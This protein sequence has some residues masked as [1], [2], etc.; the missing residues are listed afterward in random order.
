MQLSRD[1]KRFLI[2]LAAFVVVL[3]LCISHV[4]TISGWFVSALALLSPFVVGACMAFIIS[5]PMRL[6]DRI[7]RKKNKAGK[8]LVKDSTRKPLSMVLAIVL[9]LCLIVLFGMIVVPQL[10]DTVTSLA[11]SI[12]RFV[13]TA[14]RWITE[15]MNWLEGYPEIH[16]AI[17]PMVPDLNQVAASMISFV[18]KYAGIFASSL[19]SNVSSLFGSATDVII[20]FVFAIYILLQTK[21]LSR[22]GKKLL[23]AF[24]PKRFCDDVILIA[25]MAHKT[26]FSYVT[27][28]CTEAV[29]LGALCFGGMVIFRFPHALVISVI[30]LFCALIPIYGAI[31]SCVIGAF[32]V[33]IES[34]MKAIGFVAFI[35]IL[36]QLETNLIYPR[37]VSTSINLPSMWVMLAVTVGGGMF[38]VVGMLTAVPVCSIAYTLLAETTRFALR[39][40]TCPHMI[41][42]RPW[43][44]I[45]DFTL[46]KRAKTL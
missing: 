8:P 35:L 22:Q 36:Q 11:G 17:A 40:K 20:S 31:I 21:T 19:V 33:L 13:P 29:I 37:V 2:L 46:Q 10:V 12:M 16:D 15:L 42:R 9:L 23:Y 1:T 3:V 6:F 43:R 32:L 14:Q 25:R 38:G 34:P 27:I 44:R 28:Q 5:V 18:Q 41:L 30:M 4:S 7:L 24:L 39:T 26:F 45:G